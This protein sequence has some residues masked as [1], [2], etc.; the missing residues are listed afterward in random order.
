MQLN[1]GIIPGCEMDEVFKALA[2]ATRR[3]AGV[4]SSLKSR[5]EGGRSL[6]FVWKR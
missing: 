6:E 4:L 3:M 5:L 2:D 1:G